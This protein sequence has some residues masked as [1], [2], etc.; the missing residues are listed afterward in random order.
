MAEHSPE[1]SHAFGDAIPFE[2]YKKQHNP[3]VQEQVGH[4]LQAAKQT[5]IWEHLIATLKRESFVTD[6]SRGGTIRVKEQNQ[7]YKDQHEIPIYG[8]N[9]S[10]Q[11]QVASQGLLLTGYENSGPPNFLLEDIANTKPELLQDSLEA[12]LFHLS[13]FNHPEYLDNLY[14]VAQD[15]Y[16]PPHAAF[17]Q[18][19]ELAE[20]AEKVLTIHDLILTIGDADQARGSRTKIFGQGLSTSYKHPATGLLSRPG[21]EQARNLFVIGENPD[22]TGSSLML[23][24]LAAS[25]FLAGVPRDGLFKDSNRQADL[26]SDALTTLEQFAQF[27]G[28]NDAERLKLTEWYQHNLVG[29]VESEPKAAIERA[30]QLYQTGLRT[31]RV[32]SPEPN[33]GLVQTVEALRNHETT[34]KWDPIEIFAGQVVS[35]EQAIKLEQVGANA[36][37]LGVAGGGRCITGVVANLAIDWPQLLWKL[38]G[39][40]N[41]PAIVQGAANDNPLTTLA[42]GASGIGVVGKLAGSIESPGGTVYIVN[43]K[44]DELFKFY[45]GEASNRTRAAAGRWDAFNRT[46]NTE[47]ETTQ[48]SLRAEPWQGMYPITLQVL[49]S[50][51]EQLS[52][53]FVF[54]NLRNLSEVHRYAHRNLRQESRWGFQVR[55]AH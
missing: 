41:I 30:E 55:N 15:G 10:H 25:H 49:T 28:R 34:Q 23:A 50:M 44:T 1:N 36:I 35:V 12:Y 43:P 32:Y 3:T 42:L 53:S 46:I 26:A 33:L 45:G 52:T 20:E 17:S 48:R 31:F 16:A 39:K 9:S 38:R 11:A 7:P 2:E 54:Q 29:V 24:T 6:I 37:Y 4:L 19:M 27:F 8:R 5:G 22:I 47:G 18:V 14:R 21:R 51:M 40:I 13:L